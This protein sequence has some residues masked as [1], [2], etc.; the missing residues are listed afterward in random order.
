MLLWSKWQVE[1]EDIR[2]KLLKRQMALRA[3]NLRIA[4]TEKQDTEVHIGSICITW[5]RKTKGKAALQKHGDD[6]KA[7]MIMLGEACAIR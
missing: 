4:P 3:M 6:L 5:H 7:S 2:L 1:R